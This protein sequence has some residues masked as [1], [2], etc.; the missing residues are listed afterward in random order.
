ML[1]FT[2]GAAACGDAD[3]VSTDAS[4]AAVTSAD[5][6]RI[7]DAASGDATPADAREADAGSPGTPDAATIDASPVDAGNPSDLPPGGVVRLNLQ[8]S[9]RWGHAVFYS[10]AHASGG[11]DPQP[12][13]SAPV[14][15]DSCTNVDELI[16][17]D[18]VHYE[19]LDVGAEVVV[20]G[21]GESHPFL[22]D[23]ND[24]VTQYNYD[25]DFETE[26]PSWA[27]GAL[28]LELSGSAAVR[29]AR[30]DDVLDVP[31]SDL[32]LATSAT[33]TQA[34]GA[35]ET[36]VVWTPAGAHRVS[37]L[38]FDF[39]DGKVVPLCRCEARDDG[40]FTVPAAGCLETSRGE[41]LIGIAAHMFQRD[42]ELDGRRIRLD[43][44]SGPQLTMT[45]TS[46]GPE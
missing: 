30:F 27:G 2:W 3:L 18:D 4:D 31:A 25:V 9:L 23:T 34:L 16:I 26:R 35:P 28:S 8:D 10:A 43:V 36:R 19:Y 29:Q 38:W 21:G 32:R 12:P 20:S 17:E 6:A 5:V 7:P 45:R 1:L 37:F 33:I 41:L 11:V 24:G 22:R 42:L 15:T 13:V 46:T 40:E 39:A 44:S 14:D